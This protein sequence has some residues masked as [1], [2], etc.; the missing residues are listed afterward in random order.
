MA[1]SFA[2]GSSQY[3]TSANAR[4]TPITLAL[5][6]YP[7][8][9]TASMTMFEQTSTTQA[10]ANAIALVAAGASAG[11]PIQATTFATGSSF[12][13]TTTGWVVNTWYGAAHTSTGAT[14]RNAYIDGGS[15][16]N[17]TTSR[18]PTNIDRTVVGALFNDATN[19]YSNYYTGRIMEAAIWS[20]ALSA[21]ELVALAK[22]FSPL[23]IRRA[24]L[25]AYW[26]L[27][28]HY[29]QFDLDRYKSRWDLSPTNSPT[30]ADH[31]RVIYPVV[32]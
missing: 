29:G 3:L 15:S 9:D 10:A 6:F 18:A 11:D 31:G 24:S 14:D 26:P 7:T 4:N 19:A 21:A 5:R 28:G 1:R 8:A 13:A 30:W 27:G 17:N 16:G 2:G 23:L 25:V 12:A 20:V 22:G 32:G